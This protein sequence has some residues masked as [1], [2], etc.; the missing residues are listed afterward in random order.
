MATGKLQIQQLARQLFKLSLVD[1]RLSEERV[2]GVLG[3][4]EKNQAAN[5]LPLLKAYQ[6]LVAA[7]IAKGVAVV[8]HAGPVS[9][10]TFAAIAGALSQRYHRPVTTTAKANP[11]LFAGLRVRIGDDVYESSIA[12]Q[13]ATL[14]QSV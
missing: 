7:E 6:R 8:E 12:S 5:G 10:S 9:E 4:V 13:L 1:G 2:A 3:Y 14:S 11:D